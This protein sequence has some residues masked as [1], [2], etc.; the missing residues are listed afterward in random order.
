MSPLFLFSETKGF[1][2]VHTFLMIHKTFDIF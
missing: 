1:I 2:L